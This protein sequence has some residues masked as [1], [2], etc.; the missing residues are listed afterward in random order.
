SASI[1]VRL[2][3][4]DVDVVVVVGGDAA[5]VLHHAPAGAAH[6]VDALAPDD[7]LDAEGA[8]VGDGV[9]GGAVAQGLR[10]AA[11]HHAAG[12][13]H[14]VAGVVGAVVL[15]VAGEPDAADR[16]ERAHFQ[17]DGVLHL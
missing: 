12:R 1:R 15:R 2:E 16:G 10:G 8:R 6:V 14:E 17:V 11:R 9:F 4:G 13:H 5:A 3:D 7:V